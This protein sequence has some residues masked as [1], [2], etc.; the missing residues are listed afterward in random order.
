MIIAEGAVVGI[1]NWRH[2]DRLSACTDTSKSYIATLMTGV[3]GHSVRDDGRDNRD[4]LKL[5]VEQA[6]RMSTSFLQ[7]GAAHDQIPMGGVGRCILHLRHR[8][9][10]GILERVVGIGQRTRDARPDPSAPATLAH[11]DRDESCN[12]GNGDSDDRKH[13]GDGTAIGH[14]SIAH[15]SES[16]F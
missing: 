9:L 10:A 5:I 12:G 7:S 3:Y 16:A 2:P 13:T 14:K 8:R 4:I 15:M 6:S 1:A 11:D